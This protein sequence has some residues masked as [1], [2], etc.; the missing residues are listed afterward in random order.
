MFASGDDSPSIFVTSRCHILDIRPRG[1]FSL[2]TL[3][4]N[5]DPIDPKKAAGRMGGSSEPPRHTAPPQ[6]THFT[7]LAN[8]SQ[9][10][11]DKKT[12][13]DAQLAVGLTLQG[14][15]TQLDPWELPHRGPFVAGSGRRAAK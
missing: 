5:Y 6:E 12:R 11:P 3:S 7:T 4:H 2:V 13:Q 1:D 15:Q 9:Y 14:G 8:H 10:E